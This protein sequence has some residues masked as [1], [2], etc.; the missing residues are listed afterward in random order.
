MGF[1]VLWFVVF[2]VLPGP[3]DFRFLILKMPVLGAVAAGDAITGFGPNFPWPK[4]NYFA[5]SALF[6]ASHTL[7]AGDWIKLA[8]W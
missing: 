7:V 6:A 4:I 8:L 5:P 1:G 3:G 2:I